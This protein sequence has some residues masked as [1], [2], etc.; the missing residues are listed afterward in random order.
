MRRLPRISSAP[1]LQLPAIQQAVFTENLSIGGNFVTVPVNSLG[2]FINLAS[3]YVSYTGTVGS[4]SGTGPWTATITGMTSTSG[5]VANQVIL[6]VAGSGSIG[7]GTITVTSIVSSTSITIT[8]TGGTT[9]V[10]GTVTN[11][12][13]A[14]SVVS[15]AWTL[16]LTGISLSVNY[17]LPITVL[18]PVGGTAY[19]PTV[20]VNGITATL[21]GAGPSPT[22]SRTNQYFYTI[23]CTAPNQY[24]Y[25]AYANAV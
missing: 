2:T 14:G 13:T 24:S 17:A 22:T 25:F 11:I 6:A 10:A 7:T 15:S 9:P 8:A 12:I 21:I 4:I 23:V 3:Y 1:N 5:L 18:I 20:L 16:D 19:N